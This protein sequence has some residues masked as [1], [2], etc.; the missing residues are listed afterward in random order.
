[1][2]LL[3]MIVYVADYIEPNRDKA[4]RLPYYRELAF[5]DLRQCTYEILEGTIEYVRSKTAQ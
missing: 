5:K 3:D 1:M 2:N 4:P